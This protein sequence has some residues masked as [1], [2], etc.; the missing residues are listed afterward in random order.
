M[1]FTF[2]VFFYAFM[3]NVILRFCFENVFRQ[4]LIKNDAGEARDHAE[5][6]RT[7]PGKKIAPGINFLRL[8]SFELWPIY[9][10]TCL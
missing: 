3:K 7:V 6:I 5:T 2:F 9:E 8:I 4:K 10:T 1:C